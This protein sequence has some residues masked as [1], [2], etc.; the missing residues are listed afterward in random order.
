MR[1]A[2]LLIFLWV[3][4]AAWADLTVRVLDPSGAVIPGAT[5][6]LRDESGREVARGATSSAGAAEFSE[7]AAKAEVAAEGF[8]IETLATRGRRE[9]TV[10]MRLAPVTGA[11]DVTDQFEAVAP[12]A[13]GSLGSGRLGREPPLHAARAPPATGRHQLR[14]GGAR[15]KGDP[16]GNGS[17]R[18]QD[19][20]GRAG[21]HGF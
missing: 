4:T 13:S 14:A 9:V 10:R 11:L 19:V 12:V 7:A 20:R 3:A 17:R 21:T 6:V 8:L 2:R 16:A 5:V 18:H 15:P 1:V